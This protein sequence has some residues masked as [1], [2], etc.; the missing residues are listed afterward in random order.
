MYELDWAN[1]E[2]ITAD[3]ITPTKNG[4]LY[5]NGVSASAAVAAFGISYGTV[6][7]DMAF[8]ESSGKTLAAKALVNKGLTYSLYKLNMTGIQVTFVPFKGQ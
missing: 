2:T 4:M 5:C 1:K 6:T 7:L 3:S 8:S